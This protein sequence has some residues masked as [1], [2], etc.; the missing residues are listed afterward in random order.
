[1]LVELIQRALGRYPSTKKETIE[2]DSRFAELLHEYVRIGLALERL[3]IEMNEQIQAILERYIGQAQAQA[4]AYNELDKMLKDYAESRRDDFLKTGT[5]DE[6]GKAVDFG[7]AVVKF[8]KNPDRITFAP[9]EQAAIAELRAKNLAQ[10]YQVESS[11][12]KNAIKAN[13]EVL[14][15]HAIQSIKIAHGKEKIYI[16]PKRESLKGV[17]V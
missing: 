7:V 4:Q 9:D 16:M 1:M 3:E 11:V 2:S 10:Y 15:N 14:K 17:A 6:D 12:L 8:R 13:P 5:D